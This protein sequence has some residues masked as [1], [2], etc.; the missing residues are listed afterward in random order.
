MSSFT[1]GNLNF[2]KLH[3]NDIKPYTL[4]I[5]YY[6]NTPSIKRVSNIQPDISNLSLE[7]IELILNINSKSYKNLN[8]SV[9]PT[10]YMKLLVLFSKPAKIRYITDINIFTVRSLN[11]LPFI[12]SAN[13]DPN[14][15]FL[16]QLIPLF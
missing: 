11:I 14:S 7:R 12:D 9:N 5:T 16:H 6:N 3:F 8:P 10:S 4:L 1:I 13:T 2:H 15:Y